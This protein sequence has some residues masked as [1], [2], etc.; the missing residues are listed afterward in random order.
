M[1]ITYRIDPRLRIIL[2]TAHGIL[3]DDELLAHKQR[4]VRDPAFEPDMVELS[5]VRG[6]DE[7]AVTPEGIRRFVEQDREDADRFGDYKLAIVASQDVVF[8]MARMYAT[9]TEANLS[10]VGVF[11]DMEEARA[12]LHVPSQ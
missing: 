1:A 3:T 4:L 10:T 5:D 12:W 6:V 9:L 11:R 2:T 8:G 7:L